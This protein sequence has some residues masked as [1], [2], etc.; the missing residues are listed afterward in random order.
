[1]PYE[2]KPGDAALFRNKDKQEGDKRPDYTG[3]GL[4]LQGGKIRLAGWVKHGEKGLFLSI[5]ISVPAEK[6]ANS[7]PLPA[8]TESGLP[9]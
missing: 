2:Q 1:M 7:E 5:K 3:S 8:E 9:F 6:A 4:D